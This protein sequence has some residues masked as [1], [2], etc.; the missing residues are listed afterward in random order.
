MIHFVIAECACKQGKPCSCGYSPE[1]C[2]THCTAQNPSPYT[3]GY[4]LP[5]RYNNG[6]DY[7]VYELPQDA[8]TQQLSRTARQATLPQLPSLAPAAEAIQ[9][10]YQ[11]WVNSEPMKA[12]SDRFRERLSRF[13]AN[14]GDASEPKLGSALDVS[15]LRNRF[16]DRI[17][18]LAEP[19]VSQASK[20]VERF[21]QNFGLPAVSTRRRRDAPT[22]KEERTEMDKR[23]P[24]LRVKE[25]QANRAEKDDTSKYTANSR[26]ELKANDKQES[27]LPCHACGSKL[28]ASV[29]NRC[30]SYQPQYVEYVEGKQVSFYPGAK[31]LEM[32]TESS[33]EPRYI[34]DRYGHK[35]LEN[36]GN[37]RLIAP[38]QHQ[39]AIVGDQHQ[40][41]FAG[42]A[43][44]LN[45]NQEVIQQF[46]PV[47]GRIMPQPVDIA[48]GA[49]ELVRDLAR[50]EVKR[51]DDSKTEK[52]STVQATENDKK[53]SERQI[54]RSM[55]QVV[56]MQYEG[57]D[58]K[59]VVKVY[60][61]KNDKPNESKTTATDS[62]DK[63]KPTI[64]KFNKDNKTF[65][66]LTFEDY[67][68]SSNEDIRQ[69]LEHL[70]GKQ[71]W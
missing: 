16:S 18:S 59:L 49:I 32:T 56:P 11:S 4:V 7:V 15:S 58:G 34:Y 70:H 26:V 25:Y 24:M 39:E 27:S 53:T 19:F 38:Q 10:R 51:T 50:R 14:N 43:D 21:T 40:P 9:T 22:T 68:N 44:I 12:V 8:S 29:C 28:T 48:S 20:V 54:P 67:K 62:I 46:N 35:Y 60:S 30:G 3:S 55:Y 31:R 37:L 2:A 23:I 33:P 45:R 6:G 17:N 42:L 5:V 13:S 65:E 47:P 52:R 71:P 61:A 64:R 1:Q 41:D 69:V 57:K 63:S 66:V 36:N